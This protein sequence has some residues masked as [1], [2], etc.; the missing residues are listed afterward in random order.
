MHKLCV[1][2]GTLAK[3]YEKARKKFES[4]MM[5]RNGIFQLSQVEKQTG[6]DQSN[7]INVEQ[8]SS[9][10]DMHCG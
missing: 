7:I 2:D 1:Q 9:S 3:K 6:A 10:V 8:N 4:N 5:L